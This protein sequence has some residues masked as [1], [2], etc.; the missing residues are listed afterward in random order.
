MDLLAVSLIYLLPFAAG[1]VLYATLKK[2]AS[3]KANAIWQE[4]RE[5]GLT[6]P[7]SL[8]PKIDLSLCC[9]SAAC[10]ST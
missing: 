9:G 1:L 2:R 6:E 8:H 4:S 7:A 10:V 3:R 5:A